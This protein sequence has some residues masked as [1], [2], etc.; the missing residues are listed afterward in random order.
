MRKVGSL[1]SLTLIALLGFADAAAATSSID[2]L[3]RR[4]D[5]PTLVAP[6][7]DGPI[8]VDIVLH[9]DDAG[10]L[11]AFFSIQYDTAELEFAGGREHFVASIGSNNHLFPFVVGY[12]VDPSEGLIRGF[13]IA[14]APGGGGCINCS[15]TIGTVAF[16]ILKPDFDPDDIDAVGL[17]LPEGLD[18]IVPTAGGTTTDIVFNGLKVT[19][20]VP[21]PGSALLLGLGAAVIARSVRRR[22]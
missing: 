4:T 8:V 17:L 16:R 9:G 5:T 12:D 19:R 21:E 22:S 2:L 3:W 20:P 13:D 18:A 15:V 11:G 6:S 1:V 10:V 14:G 7:G